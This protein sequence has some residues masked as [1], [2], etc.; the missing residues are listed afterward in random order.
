MHT[1]LLRLAGPMQS[2]GTQSRFSIRETGLE[3]SKSGVL[4]LVCAALGRTRDAD[5]TDLAALVMG[6]RVDQQGRLAYDYHTAQDVMKAG[7]GTK[8]TEPSRRYYL[9]DAAF[10]AGLSG[11]NL[12]LLEAIH[13]ALRTPH[14]SLS[15][16]RKA[17]VPGQPVWLSDG[18]RLNTPLVDALAS[19]PWLGAAHREPDERLR[20]VLEDENGVEVRADQPLSYAERRFGP[21][22][23]TTTF[24]DAPDTRW[25]ESS[26][27]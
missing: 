4:G 25:E 11:G 8:N 22:R 5:I 10:L 19:Y 18:L 13:Q 17:F 23:V 12:A 3:P 21:R 9:A 14:W 6:V 1:L 27:I 24:V 26:C 2:W 15:L 16:G 20:V 7:G